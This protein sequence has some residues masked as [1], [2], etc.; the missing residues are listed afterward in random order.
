MRCNKEPIRMI[1]WKNGARIL[2]L[3]SFFSLL[4]LIISCTPAYQKPKVDAVWPLPPDEP[5]VKFVDFFY[6][7]A[8]IG[9][10]TGIAETLF[11]EEQIESFVKPYGV[12]VDS[13]GSIYITDV[14]RVMVFD[15]KK[16][17][18]YILGAD[19]G[20]GNLKLPI[21]IATA[22]DG[23]VFVGD[24]SADRVYVYR[25]GK[26]L[27][28]IGQTGELESPSGV[29]LDEQRKLVYVVDS[30]KHH[31]NVYSLDDYRL[32]KTMGSRG[33][34]DGDFNFP[35]NIAMDAEGNLYV[36]DTGNYRV[37]IFDPAG[38]FVRSIGR[39]GDNPGTL[40]RPKGIAIDSEGHI[41]VVDAA[42]DNFQIFD[43][44]GHLLLFV[45]EGGRG[46][47][48]FLL[49]AGITID[50]DDK[51]YVIDQFPGS[52]QIFQYL[53]EKYKKNKQ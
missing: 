1:S 15:L 31:V 23:R 53:G 14:G 21:G 50:K 30:K 40:A 12:A 5:R 41:Y 2:S 34:A 24:I 49:P 26:Y 20:T 3:L 46:P 38:K 4:S 37:Q 44:E 47:G 52:L 7:T 51:I 8:D 33:V 6:S 16:K 17:T 43:K 42:F 36:V 11:G 22:S 28:S 32:L 39:L 10:A 45:G 19:P 18:F 48:K 29:A 27:N 35:T 13:E 9:R 25:N